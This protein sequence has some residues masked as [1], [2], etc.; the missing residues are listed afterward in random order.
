MERLTL[1]EQECGMAF[2]LLIAEESGEVVEKTQKA[3]RETWFS[4]W[5][6]SAS[7]QPTRAAAATSV[8]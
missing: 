6:I 4:Y 8:C 5:P 3:G 2:P 7:D 1:P